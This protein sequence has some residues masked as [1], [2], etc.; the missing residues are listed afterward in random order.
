MRAAKRTETMSR[1]RQIIC[2]VSHAILESLKQGQ[3][4][5][6]QRKVQRKCEGQRKCEAETDHLSF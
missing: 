1:Q 3:F 2:R 6:R 4:Y 5:E